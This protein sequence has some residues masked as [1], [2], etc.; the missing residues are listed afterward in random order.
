[1]TGDL[2]GVMPVADRR[3]RHV[4]ACAT[5][6]LA[7]GTIAGLALPAG[8]GAQALIPLGEHQR[9]SFAGPA[10]DPFV[11]QDPA[12][13][14]APGADRFL[15]AWT[16][17]DPSDT[18]ETVVLGRVLDGT[19]A[20]ASATFTVRD[21]DDAE[22]RDVERPA[23][24]FN[25]DDGRFYVAY[26]GEEQ[27]NNVRDVFVQTVG[28]DGSLIGGPVNVTP[29]AG[30]SF[31]R[32]TAPSIACAAGLD[33]CLIAFEHTEDVAPKGGV[34]PDPHA[35]AR[36]FVPSTGA[37]TGAGLTLLTSF[38]QAERES[39]Q[40]SIAATGGPSA[41]FVVAYRQSEAA[42]DVDLYTRDVSGDGT[43]AGPAVKR[44]EHG[45]VGAPA[46]AADGAGALLVTW[47]ESVGGGTDVRAQRLDATA[48]G[49]PGLAPA[50]AV[51]SAELAAD[52][53]AVAFEPSLARWLVTW[54]GRTTSVPGTVDT[55]QERLSRT[56]DA[57]AA[58]V[59]PT[60]VVGGYGAQS[61]AVAGALLDAGLAARTGGGA[62]VSLT[63]GDDTNVPGI[64]TGE[65]EV[66]ARR[67]G[68]ATAPAPP[69]AP[70]APPPAAPAAPAVPR[71]PFDDPAA[72]GADLVLACADR[73][74]VLL[75]V[76]PASRGRVR[77]TGVAR[78]SFVG[79][80]LTVRRGTKVAG[81]VTVKADRTFRGL[82][83]G[84]RTARERASVR[85]TATAGATR[86][87]A[88][89]L[90]RRMTISTLRRAAGRVT[91]SG[92]VLPPL[93]R[94]R[95]AVVIERQTSCTR[96]A[97]VA[98]VRPGADGRF[99]ARFTAPAGAAVLRARTSVPATAR[100]RKLQ[101][102]FTLPQPL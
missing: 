83:A 89:K 93:G 75:D 61:S 35:A 21:I 42:A 55:K 30:P 25:P 14:Y 37:L 36:M 22:E 87:R 47:T 76:L 67:V 57:A 97:R 65:R 46:I 18:A 56:L 54:T 29:T 7:A 51:A 27:E 12:V 31:D 23:V 90:T 8:A 26:D 79:K 49:K 44:T 100:S 9:V 91:F 98:R 81:T 13:A 32:A 28:T 92:R 68:V 16:E 6:L 82:V 3:R 85:F 63:A 64:V 2:R 72:T 4:R 5:G 20:P 80:R 71:S 43:V 39:E 74:I 96:F 62:F 69:E 86:S 17:T 66:F 102:T 45:A 78:A 24:A 34:L 41:P 33:R 1:M 19:G 59:G 94:P 53:P 58:P 60:T 15:V 50:F 40:L 88:L 70:P 11:A 84:P 77:V 10:G 99:T 38:V 101:P 52:E 48:A 95:Q 73:P